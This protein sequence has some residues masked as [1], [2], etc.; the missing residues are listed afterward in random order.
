MWGTISVGAKF[1]SFLL[2]SKAAADE[3]PIRLL[4]VAIGGAFLVLLAIAE[5]RPTD[6][7]SLLAGGAGRGGRWRWR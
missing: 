5:Q 4:Y 6:V 7:V 3:M 2:P 1:P